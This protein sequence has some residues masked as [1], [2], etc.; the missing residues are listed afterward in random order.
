M[1]NLFKN[2]LDITLESTTFTITSMMSVYS[3]I[4]QVKKTVFDIIYYIYLLDQNFSF[5][6]EIFESGRHKQ[7]NGFPSFATCRRLHAD[8]VGVT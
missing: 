5:L 1:R 3:L 4:C 6:M 2:T 8:F 7:P